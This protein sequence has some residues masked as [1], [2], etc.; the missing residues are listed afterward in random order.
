MVQ[1]FKSNERLPKRLIGENIRKRKKNV[2]F[3]QEKITDS[4]QILFSNFWE[5][6]GLPVILYPF[7]LH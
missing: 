3:Y 6:I 1:N 7:K 2:T 4:I 5:K